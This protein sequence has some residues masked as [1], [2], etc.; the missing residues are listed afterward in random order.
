MYRNGLMI[1]KIL[2]DMWFDC[3]DVCPV[4]ELKITRR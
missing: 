1:N 3:I 2:D 4:L